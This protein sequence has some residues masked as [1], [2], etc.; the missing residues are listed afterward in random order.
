MSRY[1]QWGHSSGNRRSLCEAALLSLRGSQA[2]DKGVRFGMSRLGQN[3]HLPVRLRHAKRDEQE[4]DTSEDR[5]K[6]EHPPPMN[7]RD[8]H[9]PANKGTYC[10]SCERGQCKNGHGLSTRAGLPYVGDDS[11]RYGKRTG[12]ECTAEKTECKECASIW[13]Q[14]ATDKHALK[15]AVSNK[16][17]ALGIGLVRTV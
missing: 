11:T 17:S 15:M 13:G 4:A 14:G 16:V 5:E 6:P 8:L 12:G 7:A 2:C 1:A 9:I 3:R 10:R